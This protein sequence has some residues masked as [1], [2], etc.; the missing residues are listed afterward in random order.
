MININQVKNKK[1]WGYHTL[2][3]R[4]RDYNYDR[5]EIDPHTEIDLKPYVHHFGALYVVSGS[6][7]LKSKETT[8]PII[9]NGTSGFFSF[10]N[11]YEIIISTENGIIL[12]G[13]SVNDK[14]KILKEGYR[15]D[16][17]HAWGLGGEELW[18]QWNERNCFKRIILPA[19]RVTSLQFHR[20]KYETN[21]IVEGHARVYMGKQEANLEETKANLRV[22]EAGPGNFFPVPIGLVHRIEALTNL[23]LLEAS[24][25]HVDDVVRLE[26]ATG[27]TDG[28]ILSEHRT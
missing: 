26:D 12:Q 23:V 28:K 20:E 24:T 10:N 21:F 7:R 6:G 5:F 16:K 19:G 9:A 25:T 18:L 11:L 17:S 1:E 22:I 27:R 3:D 4:H 8:T 2:L 14:P 13:V 15:V